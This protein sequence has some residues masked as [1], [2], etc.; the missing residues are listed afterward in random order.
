MAF[1]NKMISN[2]GTTL[3]SNQDFAK[4][5]I[6]N[7]ESQKDILSMPDIKNPVKK[8][9]NKKV[10]FNRRVEK[11]LKEADVSVYIT[12]FKYNLYKDRSRIIKSTNIEIGV[13]CH[14]ECQDTFNGLRDAALVCCIVD[15]ITENEEISGI[16]KIK[17]ESCSPMFNL[18]T[19][20]NGFSIVVSA[21]SFGDM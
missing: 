5:M 14:D 17:L 6:Y 13:V 16:G 1:P 2:I 21:E 8:L 4:F 9:R 20:Y 7:D 3:M 10:F 18:D 15:A 12:L 11:V 19:S